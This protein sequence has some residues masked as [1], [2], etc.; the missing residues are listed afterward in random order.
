MSRTLGLGFCTARDSLFILRTPRG[1]LT[2]LAR[3]VLV[4][5][6]P[7]SNSASARR[8]VGSTDWRDDDRARV[9]LKRGGT[10][11]KTGASPREVF[12]TDAVTWTAGWG[13]RWPQFTF[14]QRVDESGRSREFLYGDNK[15]TPAV[16]TTAQFPSRKIRKTP[17]TS[18]IQLEQN[19]GGLT[20]RKR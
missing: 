18:H 13:K 17:D 12:P 6:S 7:H 15:P 20:L 5:S 4:E 3:L 9:I 1:D 19:R 16:R 11:H 2:Y 14:K 8:M 10:R